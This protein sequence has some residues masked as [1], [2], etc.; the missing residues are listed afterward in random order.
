MNNPLIQDPSQVMGLFKK[1]DALTELEKH[2][3]VIVPF[4]DIFWNSDDILWTACRYSTVYF[5]WGIKVFGCFDLDPS[6]LEFRFPLDDAPMLISFGNLSVVI[7]PKGWDR[8]PR[9]LTLFHVQRRAEETA[10][11]KNESVKP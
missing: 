10:A 2:T 9:V 3:Y 1:D 4:E 7:A 8:I 11:V 5:N 6:E